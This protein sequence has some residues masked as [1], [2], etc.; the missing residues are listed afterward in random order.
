MHP[1]VKRIGQKDR[2]L[3]RLVKAVI[4]R[5]RDHSDHLQRAIAAR[6][7]QGIGWF[8]FKGGNFQRTS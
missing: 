8:I 4:Q 1:H 5:V 6:R 3:Y 7:G 2:R